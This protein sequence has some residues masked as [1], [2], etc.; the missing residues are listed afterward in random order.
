MHQLFNQRCQNITNSCAL[1]SYT[2]AST[3]SILSACLSSIFWEASWKYYPTTHFLM[4]DSRNPHLSWWARKWTFFALVPSL[5]LPIRQSAYTWNMCSLVCSRRKTNMAHPLQVKRSIPSITIEGICPLMN[6][7]WPPHWRLVCFS[8]LSIFWETSLCLLKLIQLG[9]QSHTMGNQQ[10]SGS[11]QRQSVSNFISPFFFLLS[12][13]CLP[14]PY[15][16]PPCQ[17]P[18][19]SS[20]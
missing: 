13:M 14:C 17:I 2:E 12:L 16:N 1:E 20:F 7:S 10:L 11:N 8:C 9:Q 3:I 4:S 5:S 18:V 6:K 19:H 15:L